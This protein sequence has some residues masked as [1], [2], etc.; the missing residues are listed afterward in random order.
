MPT[1]RCF[2]GTRAAEPNS[3]AKVLNRNEEYLN[4][5]QAPVQL[6]FCF[7]DEKRQRPVDERDCDHAEDPDRFAPGIEEQGED[8]KDRVAPAK[9]SAAE[10]EQQKRRQ[11]HEQKSRA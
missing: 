7:A 8:Q 3:A 10:I 2:E 9:I 1:G 5:K 11:K 4:Q 6:V